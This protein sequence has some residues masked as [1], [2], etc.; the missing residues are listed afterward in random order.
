MFGPPGTGKTMIGRCIAAQA[1]ATFFSIT[2]STLTSKW[3]GDGEKAMKAMFYLARCQKPSVIF[4]DEIDSLLKSRSDSEHE[5]SRRM[6]TEFLSQFD[7]LSNNVNDGFLVIG[8]TNRPQ[9]LD[10]AVRRRF[11]AKL[12]IPLP[13]KSARKQMI[14]QNL[15]DEK[16]SL[17][18]TEIDDLAE[19]TADYSGSDI[20]HLC[21]EAAMYS[22]KEIIEDLSNIEKGD[23]RA[24][25]NLDFLQALNTIKP[26]LSTDDLQEYENWNKRYGS[27]N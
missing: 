19:K 8:T 7:G 6:K 16:H 5:S 13:E 18:E 27:N 24:I 12:Y 22:F 3:I 4:I 1:N 23:I 21:R 17:T 14:I 9:E 11:A 2:S 10:E 15:K 26:S 25:N 20:K